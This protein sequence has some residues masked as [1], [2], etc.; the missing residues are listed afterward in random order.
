MWL[1]IVVIVIVI[2]VI[3]ARNTNK[4]SETENTESASKASKSAPTSLAQ[5]KYK[6]IVD[7]LIK[8][9]PLY[10]VE[11]LQASIV[12]KGESVYNDASFVSCLV[13]S[14]EDKL[15]YFCEDDDEYD[16]LTK[17]YGSGITDRRPPINGEVCGIL[18]MGLFYYSKREEYP[19]SEKIKY[20]AD[21]LISMA[22]AGDR[23]AQAGL[24]ARMAEFLATPEDLAVYR[25]KY[26]KSLRADASNDDKYAQLAVARYL[27]FD[28]GEKSD[29][30]FKA[31]KQGLTDAWFL[32]AQNFENLYIWKDENG[33][34][35]KDTSD[36]NLRRE[37]KQFSEDEVKEIKNT[38][39]SAYLKGA[40]CA[41]GVY[42]A[43]CMRFVGEFYNPLEDYYVADGIIKNKLTAIEWYQKA[44]DNG[45]KYLDGTI[46]FLRNS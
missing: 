23:N 25:Q 17:G 31:A 41:N 11:W 22:Q 30:L 15:P 19:Y 5:Y 36:W 42:T 35:R 1:I 4:S 18:S 37:W 34:L 12:K 29:L 26:E 43:E 27:T 3:A 7:N 44:V 10:A 38:W 28:Y 13:R 6:D 20:W 16:A 24:C 14:V 40:E 39:F 2:V 32:Y 8:Q 45:Y 9:M 33:V 46:E 21:V